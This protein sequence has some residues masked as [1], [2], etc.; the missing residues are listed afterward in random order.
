V[1]ARENTSDV[2]AELESEDPWEVGDNMI[3]FEEEGDREVATSVVRREPTATSIGTEQE[4]E[5]HGDAP[6]PRKH[7]TSMDAIGEREEK[8]TRSPRPSEASSALSPLALAQRG[9]PGGQ[10]SGLMPAHL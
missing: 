2:K 4:A 1:W 5:R 3:S 9:K 7:A 8:R 10:R 6:T